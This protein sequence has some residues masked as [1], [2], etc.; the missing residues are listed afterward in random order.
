MFKVFVF[1]FGGGAANYGLIERNSH[2]KQPQNY[3][4]P[5][6]PPPSL[7][8]ELMCFYFWLARVSRGN[9]MTQ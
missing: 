7:G 4:L 6:S 5:Q 1:F 8:L 3:P 2:Q 9:L